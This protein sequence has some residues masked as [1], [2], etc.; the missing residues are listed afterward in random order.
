MRFSQ[1]LLEAKEIKGDANDV[2][3][4]TFVWLPD[5]GLLWQD[6]QIGAL[7]LNKKLIQKGA[8]LKGLEAHMAIFSAFEGKEGFPSRDKW[9]AIE[10]RGRLSKDKKKIVVHDWGQFDRKLELQYKKCIDAVYKYMI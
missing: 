9:N 1:F 3:G 5:K 7:Y 6:G 8:W 2:T 4:N 10:I